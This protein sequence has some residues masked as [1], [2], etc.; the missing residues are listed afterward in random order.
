MLKTPIYHIWGLPFAARS[1]L[2]GSLDS[3]LV[4][5]LFW[6]PVTDRPAPPPRRRW[7]FPSWSWVGWEGITG[8]S[9]AAQSVLAPRNDGR[10]LLENA[11]GKL[12]GVHDYVRHMEVSWDIHAFKPLMHLTGWITHVRIV[13]SHSGQAFDNRVADTSGHVFATT[14]VSHECFQ[15]RPA[16]FTREWPVILFFTPRDSENNVSVNGLILRRSKRGS[17]QRVGNLQHSVSCIV[18]EHGKDF[19]QLKTEYSDTS[20]EPSSYWPDSSTVATLECFR[21]TI[22]LV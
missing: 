22:L 19:V 13:E 2:A 17:H 16:L 10:V 15:D 6:S 9:P 11:D 5:S 8:I 21:R 20:Y 4:D 1:N 3:R 14:D 18:G 12:F 7:E